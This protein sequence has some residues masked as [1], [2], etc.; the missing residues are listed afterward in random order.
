M[1]N[2]AESEQLHLRHRLVGG[3]AFLGHA[4]GRDGHAGAIVAEATVHKDFYAKAT[5]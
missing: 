3:P 1:M 2:S 5:G 4:V